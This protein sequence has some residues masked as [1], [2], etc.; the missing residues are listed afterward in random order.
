MFYSHIVN[1]SNIINNFETLVRT[2]PYDWNT[3]YELAKLYFDSGQYSAAKY[4]FEFAMGQ[5]DLPSDIN[6]KI[7]DYLSKIR[8][9]K[10]WDVEFGI[11]AIPDSSINY[12]PTNRNECINTPNGLI[13]TEIEDPT[14]G[15]GYQINGSVNYYKQ[16]YKKIGIRTTFGGAILNTSNNIPTDYSGH[17]AIGPR[18]VFSFGDISIQPSFGT[19]MYNSKLY[20][21]SYGIRAIST[22]QIP[23]K[24]FTDIGLDIQK[25]HY[26]TQTINDIL[27][28]VDWTFYIHPKYYLTDTSF[29]SFT[30]ALSHSHTK[31]SALGAD[32]GRIAIGYLKIFP[33]GFN[34]YINMM[35]S[36]SAYH[37][38]GIFYL[39]NNIQSATRHDNIYQIYT[40]IYNSYINLYNFIPAISYTYTI[41]DS[42]I[43]TYNIQNNQVM[44]ELVK[45]F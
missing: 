1:A 21:F 18:Y 29:I 3:R 16:L 23:N 32:I 5:H 39:E 43:P 25:N 24:L 30:A 31:L 19:R 17:F 35:Y 11:G 34:F 14:S 45:P 20:N 12:S 37:A 42:N 26:Y 13:C 9:F 28:G 38:S 2:H 22:L 7:K 10:T 4:H 36:H 33:C 6:K 44:I 8:Q 40:R 15:I 27:T 41:Q